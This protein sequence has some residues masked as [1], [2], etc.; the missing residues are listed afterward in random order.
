[1]VDLHRQYLAIKEE[2]DTAIQE[3]INS[4]AFIRGPQVALFE[5]ELASYL[6][7]KHVV[8]C[9]NG[10]DALQ[11]A[12]MALELKPGDEVIT[13]SFTFIATVEVIA[14]LGLTPVFAEVDPRTYNIDPES[15]KKKITSRTRA[16]IPVHLFGQPANMDAIMDIARQHRL[17]VVEDACQA[18]GATYVSSNG[19]TYKAGTTGHIGCTSFFPSKNLGCFGDGGALFTND[20]QLA[21]KIRMIANH[22]MKVRYYHDTIGVNSRLDTLQAAILR[23]KLKYLD[24]YNKKRQQAAAFYDQQLSAI[25]GIRIPIRMPAARHIYHQYTLVVEKPD[26]DALRKHLEAKGIPSMIYYP[27]P[28]HLQKAYTC[29]GYKEG[30]LPITEWLSKHVLSLPM[31]TELDNEQLEYICREIKIFCSNSL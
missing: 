16:I 2:I 30:D 3:V 15:I 20:D 4:T 25:N 5:Q 27:V 7:V 23:V 24:H 31:H 9:G 13:P 10:T 26:R 8:A 19:T 28:I 22:G 14:L 6:N 17:Y 18:T 21:E 12:L 29:Y 1:M 11:I